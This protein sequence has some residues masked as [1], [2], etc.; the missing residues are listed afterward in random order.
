MRRMLAVLLAIGIL[1]LT[2][3]TA[4]R[5]RNA[6]ERWRAALAEA[7]EIRFDAAITARWPN[8]AAQFE[9]QVVRRDGQTAATVTAPGPIAGVTFRRSEAGDTLE[10]DGLILDMDA[11]QGKTVAP[12]EGPGLLLAA[13]RDGWPLSYGREGEY[14]TTELEAPDG[15]TV[16]LRRTADGTPVNAEIAR[17]GVTEITLTIDHWVVKG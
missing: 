9:V 4:A 14:S 13:I 1:P 11:G 10:F 8:S 16:T 12:C 5:D 2:G 3:C 7:E 15:T 6:F 17:G